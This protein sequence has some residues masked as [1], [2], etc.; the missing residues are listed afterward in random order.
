M[1]CEFAGFECIVQI[2]TYANPPNLGIELLDTEDGG[3][4]ATAT[5]NPNYLLP[6]GHVLVK[7]Y[8][9]NEGVLQA[10]SD[11]GIV[12]FTGSTVQVGFAEADLCRL[13]MGYPT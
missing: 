12:V 4:V 8:S 1:K 7:N 13:L 10:L 2:I 11:A 6:A 5:I 3:P 9:E